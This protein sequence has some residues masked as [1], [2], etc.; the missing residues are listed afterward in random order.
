MQIGKGKLAKIIY[1]LYDAQ[2][3]SLLEQ[4]PEDKALVF[5]FGIN[6]LFPEF[7]KNLWGLK[8]GDTFD[9]IIKAEDAFGPIDTYA[10]FDIPKETFEVDGKIPEDFF[11]PGKKI[12]M[13]DNNG[14]RHIGKMIKILNDAV[15]MDFNHPLAGKDL[16]YSGKVVEVIDNTQNN[17]K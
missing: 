10:I 7:E 17:R 9:F 2:D 11:Q 3:G 1:K 5:R 12:S 14:N 16:R 13:H 15:T 6:H 4:I 8:A